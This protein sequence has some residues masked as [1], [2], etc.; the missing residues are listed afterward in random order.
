MMTEC[1][2]CLKDPTLHSFT[3]I[4]VWKQ[5]HVFYTSF[6]NVKEY[7]PPQ[8]IIDHMSA[9]LD[10]LQNEPWVW[11]LDCQHFSG[12]H[13]S[14]APYFTGLIQ[15]FKERY[16]KSLHFVYIINGSSLLQG[17]ISLV[18]PMFEK[19]VTDI[20]RYMR[21]SPLEM[22]RQFEAQGWSLREIRP[23]LDRVLAN[24]SKESST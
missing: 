17:T 10:P 24:Q 18:M 14:K 19:G 6:L 22:T 13:A 3:K 9:T 15:L 4:G 7:S 16:S 5:Y 11:V 20:L 23:I 21:G 8:T 2:H 12:K 1:V